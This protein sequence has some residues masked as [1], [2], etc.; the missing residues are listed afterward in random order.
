MPR[1]HPAPHFG[2]TMNSAEVDCRLSRLATLV[3]IIVLLCITPSH[4]N[5][6]SIQAASSG[7]SSASSAGEGYDG[8]CDSESLA[9]FCLVALLCTLSASLISSIPSAD[10]DAISPGRAVLAC[11]AALAWLGLLVGYSIGVL[12][13]SPCN[14]LG[15]AA[16]LILVYEG[17]DVGC[18]FAEPEE[19][20]RYAA[21]SLEP[22]ASVKVL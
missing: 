7:G 17:V 6:G 13:G 18:C 2:S 20:P 8:I 11:L 21:C 5:C 12:T 1:K 9:A 3:E 10:V 19:L 22:I 14:F 15:L 16:A 4:Y